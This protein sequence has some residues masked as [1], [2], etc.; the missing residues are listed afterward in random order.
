MQKPNV[1][2]SHHK[3]KEAKKRIGVR[4]Q[5]PRFFSDRNQTGRATTSWSHVS[6]S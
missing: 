1:R 2:H 4:Y 6:G 3:G 5:A